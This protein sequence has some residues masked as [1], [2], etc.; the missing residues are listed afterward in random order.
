MAQDT[1]GQFEDIKDAL[2]E[3]KEILEEHTKILA[4]VD[5]TLAL[6][7]Q[8]LEQHMRRTELAEENIEILRNELKPVEKH[9]AFVN[10]LSKLITLVGTAVGIVYG[11][12]QVMNSVH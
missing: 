12:I 5:K 8:H 10:G 6:Q 7:A 4:S 9:V 1:K 3:H 11:I 2:K